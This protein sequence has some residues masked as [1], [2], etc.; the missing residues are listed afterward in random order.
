LFK[1]NRQF[2]KAH[3]LDG[4][5]E[6]EYKIINYLNLCFFPNFV[7]ESSF[8]FQVVAFDMNANTMA[9]AVKVGAVAAK[10]PK[11]VKFIA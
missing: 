9:E 1:F 11:E 10:G 2:A 3:H 6:A 5:L 4:S 8:H 7:N